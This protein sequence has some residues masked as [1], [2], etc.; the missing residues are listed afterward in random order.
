M[1]FTLPSK[2]EAG[3]LSLTGS[4]ECNKPK[5]IT[6]VKKPYALVITW[7]VEVTVPTL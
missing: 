1:Q 3:E 5:G 6:Q 2:I 7:N 4:N